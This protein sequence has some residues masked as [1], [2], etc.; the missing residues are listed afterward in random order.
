M[1]EEKEFSMEDF[2]RRLQKNL[3]EI[4]KSEI[5]VQQLSSDYKVSG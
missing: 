3:E 4:I 1:I 5:G 2:E